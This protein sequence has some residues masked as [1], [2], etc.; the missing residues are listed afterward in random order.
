MGGLDLKLL[1]VNHDS[2]TEKMSYWHLWYVNFTKNISLYH[3]EWYFWETF[4]GEEK[5]YLC[6]YNSVNKSRT[7]KVGDVPSNLI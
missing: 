1:S 4:S 6:W 7:K 5:S 2:I 3:E